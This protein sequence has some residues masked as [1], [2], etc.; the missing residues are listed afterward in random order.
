MN[1]IQCSLGLDLG[2]SGIKAVLLADD[3]SLAAVACRDYSLISRR[4]G[5]AETDPFLWESAAQSVIKEA[6]QQAPHAEICGIGID[7]Q[8]HGTV[9]VDS[10]GRPVRPAILWPDS[11][12]STQLANWKRMPVHTRSALAN[13]IV[14]GMAGPI[15]SW[16]F[17]NEAGAR[18]RVRY[19]LS[20]KDWL[21][22]RFIPG[23]FVTDASDASATLLWNVTTDCW[24]PAA[25]SAAHIPSEILPRVVDSFAPA[26][27]LGRE[28]AEVWGLSSGTPV[29]VGCGDVPATLI[30]LNASSGR[31]TIVIGTGAQIVLPDAEP[32]PEASPKFHTYRSAGPEYYAMSTVM[33]A[34]LALQNVIRLLRADWEEL[35]AT[36]DLALEREAPIFLP[37]F[38]G[39][40]LPQAI[41]ANQANWLEI[42]LN[43][44]RDELMRAALEGV[45][46]AIRRSLE[47]LPSARELTADVAGGGSRKPRFVQMLADTIR[48][49]LRL[50]AIE[51]PTA[52][53]AAQLGWTASG[54]GPVN[55]P[56]ERPHVFTPR[57]SKSLEDRYQRFLD[58]THHIPAVGRA[59]AT[60]AQQVSP[61][62]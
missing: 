53:G 19:M 31:Y 40:R 35:Y 37:F 62:T 12:A 56:A 32:V 51:S 45:A 23:S 5:W 29:S 4:P 47:S 2:T 27:E 58:L 24:D 18:N 52:V 36:A 15:V 50:V 54:R 61:E 49:P 59:N 20:P 38:S 16:V 9:L 46:F 8:M 17:R 11:R 10:M 39:E 3:G 21:R 41:G 33:N 6:L 7:G 48:R 42:G 13:P 1:Q 22:S 26:G 57:D 25:A 30:G 14:P 44:S 28:S 34:G 55:L 60:H 43:T